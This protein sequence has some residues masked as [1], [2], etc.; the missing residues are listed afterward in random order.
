MHEGYVN[1]FKFGFIATQFNG[2][3]IVA[4][5][6]TAGDGP[7]RADG[8]GGDSSAGETVCCWLQRRR[9]IAIWRQHK[10]HRV[11]L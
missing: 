6:G 3:H 8:D 5:F 1:S 7:L 2:S 9:L 10:A 4:L 11:V